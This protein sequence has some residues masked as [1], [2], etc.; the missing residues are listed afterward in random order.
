MQRT[1]GTVVTSSVGFVLLGPEQNPILVNQVAAEI[2]S[3]PQKPDT[4]K[5]LE[6]F[7]AGK[8]RSA[9]ISRQPSKELA[10]APTFRSGKRLYLC[11]AFQAHSGAKGHSQRLVAVLLERG[12]VGSVSLLQVSERFHLT[13][14]EHEVLQYL[15][16][17]L[18][19]KEI[20]AR[21]E[22]SPNTVK[23]FLRLIMIKMGVSTRS[24]IVGKAVTTRPDQS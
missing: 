8:I 23:A 13:T 20:G 21:M 14:R 16:Q 4:L 9:L 6:G 17:G 11:R 22:I 18:T 2:L 5:G 24:G 10:I 7:L 1:A 3:Y 12:S 15:L 19:S